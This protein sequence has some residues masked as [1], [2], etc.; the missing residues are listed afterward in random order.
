ME[1]R[2]DQKFKKI[3]LF[4][5]DPSMLNGQLLDELSYTYLLPQPSSIHSI[6]FDSSLPFP[7]PCPEEKKFQEHELSAQVS[8]L[9]KKERCSK[10]RWAQDYQNFM[11]RNK[12][13]KLKPKKQDYKTQNKEEEEGS[14]HLYAN[15]YEMKSRAYF[16]NLIMVSL[17][18]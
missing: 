13:Q 2:R 15:I 8:L 17:Y 11:K 9:V 1:K 12:T 4:K 6:I 16:S 3:L 10:K 5:C 14:L 7:N 18:M